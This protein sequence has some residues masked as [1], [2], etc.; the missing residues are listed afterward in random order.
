[1]KKIQ[2]RILHCSDH[3][4]HLMYSGQFPLFMNNLSYC[5]D[6]DKSFAAIRFESI[7]D[8]YY[9]LSDINNSILKN[10]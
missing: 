7:K 6:R 2:V 4:V 1:M 9:R 8:I 3:S 10:Y 5:F